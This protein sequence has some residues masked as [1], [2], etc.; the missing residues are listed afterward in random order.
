M[1]IVE[2]LDIRTY[3]NQIKC[4]FRVGNQIKKFFKNNC[5]EIEYSEDIEDV[6]EGILIIPFLTNILPIVWI[7]NSKIKINEIDKN[8]YLSIEKIKKGYIDMYPETKFLG[9][10]IVDKIIDYSYK[11]TKQT[12]T[13]FSGG[14]DSLGTLVTI[15]KKKPTL[16]TLWGSDIKLTNFSG[17]EVV[18]KKVEEYGKKFEL[19]NLFIK[20]NFREFINEAELDKKYEK[21]LKDGWWHGIQHGIGLI[22]HAI[23]IAYKNKMQTIY[24]P[25]TLN[26]KDINKRLRCASYPTIDE[27]VKYGCGNVIHEGF[28]NTRQDKI[29]IITE[30][31]EKNNLKIEARVCWKGTTG[32]NCCKCEKCYRTIMGLLAEGKDPNNYGFIVDKSK[33]LEIEYKLKKEFI[34]SDNLILEWETIRTKFLANKKY[35]FQSEWILDADFK[36]NSENNRKKAIIMKIPLKIFRIIKGFINE[37][38]N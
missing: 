19:P 14:V 28:N 8:F 21:Q 9:E 35:L 11:P 37:K 12:C 6:P 30:F 7:T 26:K 32:N 1:S 38:S 34:L 16:V 22:G 17:W 2:V 31:S 29:Q 27:K 13:F 36:K 25:G 20:S 15:N 24:I 18:K 4:E 10:I 23:P 33:V 3:K 5:F